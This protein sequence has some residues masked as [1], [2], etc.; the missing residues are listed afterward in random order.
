MKKYSSFLQKRQKDVAASAD[1]TPDGSLTITLNGFT[2]NL[3][4]EQAAKLAGK[5][6]VSAVVPDEILHPV[7]VP[8]TEFLGLEG[9]NGVWNAVGGIG[10]AGA[11]TVVGVIDTG[12][13]PENPS[14][15]GEP[16][17]TAAGGEPYLDGNVVTYKKADGGTFKSERVAGQSWN[18]DDYSTKLIGAKYFSAGAA[19]TGYKF[20]SDFLSPRDGDG[21]GSHT[22]A[23][24]AGNNG[25]DAS[26]EGVDFGA[27]SG[28]APAAKVAAYKACYVGPDVLVSTDDI[29][30]LSDLM[31]AINAAVADG[32]D[33][34]NYSIGGGAATTHVRHRG[35]RVLQRGGG[36]HLRR[37]QRGQRRARAPATADHAS[38]WYT[39]V[40]AS[41]VPTYEGTVTLPERLHRRRRIRLGAVRRG[42]HRAGGR[43]HRR[44]ARR[45]RRPRPRR[46][47]CSEPSTRR[48]SPARSSSATAG[49]NARVEKSLEVSNAGGVGMI[50]VNV[51]PGSLDNDFHSVPTVHIQN[52]FRDALLAGVRAPAA[53]RPRCTVRTS[54]ASRRRL[55]WSPASRAAD[56]CW[57]MAATS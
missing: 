39:T 18:N 11:G 24:A 31:G 50:L 25:V 28:V 29:C 35:P 26:V 48:S 40:A 41:T 5:T 6:G 21:H 15:A 45:G 42:G 54:P 3:T 51:T 38:P 20:D 30:A 9:D 49:N 16:L 52:T 43:L 33:V 8:S 17:S 44:Q 1:V 56:R 23:T 7:A 55:P 36:R 34:I 2:A 32:V 37:C 14:F 10:A 12:I 46:S 27:V 13:A 22:A 19:A 47:A 57:P 4:A 53:R